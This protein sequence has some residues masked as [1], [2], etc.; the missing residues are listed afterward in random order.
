MFANLRQ[1]IEIA[2][3]AMNIM[4]IIG[5]PPDWRDA[6]ALKTYLLDVLG[7]LRPLAQRTDTAFDDQ[8]LDLLQ[9]WI[10][11][12]R[13]FNGVHGVILGILAEVGA[14]KATAGPSTAVKLDTSEIVAEAQ[15]CG[16]DPATILAIVG[17][18]IEL[19]KWIRERRQVQ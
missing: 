3:A 11:N 12:D 6:A 5:D 17:L 2:K 16:I 19:V 14:P 8:A 7:T 4:E 10:E 15:K 1:W 9:A 13:L 18:A